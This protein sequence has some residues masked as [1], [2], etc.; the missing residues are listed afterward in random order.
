MVTESIIETMHRA[1]MMKSPEMS[2]SDDDIESLKK[3]EM[4]IFN[5]YSE[6]KQKGKTSTYDNKALNALMVELSVMID[7]F[8]QNKNIKNFV[9][10]VPGGPRLGIDVRV[11]YME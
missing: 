11:K 7:D 1:K 8:K 10:D 5:I 4:C 3:L 6:A 9:S 2:L